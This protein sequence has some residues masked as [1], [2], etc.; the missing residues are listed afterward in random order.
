MG[1]F[2]DLNEAP[3]A[4]TP[5]ASP[6]SAVVWLGAA[7]SDFASGHNL[8][9]LATGI[10]INTSG[11]PSVVARA[12]NGQVLTMVG[13]VEAWAAPA[14]GGVTDHGALTG[15][16]DND[17]PH[18]ALG[19]T[20]FTAGAGMT[21]GGDL[22]G[23]R[24]FN[25]IAANGTIVVNADSIQ[26]GEIANANVAAAAAIAHAKLADLAGLSLLGRS[27]AGSGA[28]AAITASAD[29]QLP[30]H[31]GSAVTFGQLRAGSAAGTQT[32]GFVLTL[33]A[34]VP[35]WVAAAGGVTDHGAL[36][37]LSDDDHAVYALL[38]GR[39]TGQTLIGGLASGNNLSLQSTADATRGT[40]ISLDNF[41]VTR[42]ASGVPV[43]IAV[44]NTSNTANSHTDLTLTHGG[45][46]GGRVGLRFLGGTREWGFIK[47]AG[48]NYMLLQDLTAVRDRW[49][50][51]DTLMG[52]GHSGPTAHYHFVRPP[53]GGNNTNVQIDNDQTAGVDEILIRNTASTV[54]LFISVNGSTAGTTRFDAT[55]QAMAEITAGGTGCAGMLIGTRTAD[56][57]VFGTDDDERFRIA[58]NGSITSTDDLGNVTTWQ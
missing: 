48:S 12:A 7:H 17:H 54:D 4:G 21:G 50:I 11:T 18:Y 36:T 37:G 26:V 23:A 58:A 32:N 1:L 3:D 15:L 28:M 40:V 55:S 5:G 25:V 38:A 45:T 2:I 53:G 16:A 34:G 33:S 14:G 39:G 22:S 8:G 13:G 46:S 20:V 29:G 44:Q 24:T 10:V 9:A 35:T 43:S 49:S 19:A 42:S 27:A 6:S 41:S 31:D 56:P 51:N 47:N 30:R 57:L 52:F